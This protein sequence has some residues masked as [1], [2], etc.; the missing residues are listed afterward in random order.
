MKRDPVVGALF[1]AVY[2]IGCAASYMV[3]TYR[4]SRKGGT[5][6]PETVVPITLFW[7][8]V[9]AGYLFYL[10]L[11]APIEALNRRWMAYLIPPEPP[12]DPFLDQATAEVDAMLKE[13]A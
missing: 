13:P 8:I 7:P 10:L 5:E 3:A 6:F 2:I 4:W 1:L 11:I 12:A 9:V